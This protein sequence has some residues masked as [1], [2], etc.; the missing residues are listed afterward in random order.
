MPLRIWIREKEGEVVSAR[1]HRMGVE[2]RIPLLP[3]SSKFEV[4]CSGSATSAF[5]KVRRPHAVG[6]REWLGMICRVSP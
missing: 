6:S 2:V 5:V 4:V 1:I 3:L